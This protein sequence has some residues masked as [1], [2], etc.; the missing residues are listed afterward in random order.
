MQH[1]SEVHRPVH[2][3]GWAKT[4]IAEKLGMSRNT[5]RTVNAA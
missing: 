2:R 3:E 5:V 4:K 1:W